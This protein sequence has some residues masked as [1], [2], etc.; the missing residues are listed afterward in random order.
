MR[1]GNAT[2]TR[3]GSDKLDLL[4]LAEVARV[5]PEPMN[6]G[7]ESRERHLVVEV[8]IGHDRHR[9]AWDDDRQA[10]GRLLLVAG[11]SHD[12]RAGSGER[13]HLGEGR[14]GVRGLRHGHRLH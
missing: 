7:L 8:H 12:V 1:I 5:Q 13:V 4:G 10:L 11:A 3:F 6:S 14:L 9:R 2:V